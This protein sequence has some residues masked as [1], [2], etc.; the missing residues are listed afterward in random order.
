MANEAVGMAISSSCVAAFR[1]VEAK[2]E[3]RASSGSDKQ[4]RREDRVESQESRILEGV[5]AFNA[6]DCSRAAQEASWPAACAA[7]ARTRMPHLI[8]GR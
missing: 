7:K 3:G 1:P 6:H 2:H 5:P 8:Q 4:I